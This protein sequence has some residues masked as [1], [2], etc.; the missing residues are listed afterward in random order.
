MS[1]KEHNACLV[2]HISERDT[3]YS[4]SPFKEEEVKIIEHVKT[5]HLQ[6]VVSLLSDTS[7][8]GPK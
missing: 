7:E 8:V 6:Q 3:Q 1:R 2:Y 5:N 4:Y